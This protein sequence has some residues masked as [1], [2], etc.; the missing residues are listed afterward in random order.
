MAAISFVKTKLGPT[1]LIWLEK[2]NTYFQLEEPAWFVFRRI[3]KQEKPGT[4]AWEFSHRYQVSLSE[5]Q[6]FVGEIWNKI[7]GVN[8]SDSPE[9]NSEL[10]KFEQ[11]SHD[12][13]EPYSVQQYQLGNQIIEFR[14]G[15][16]WLENYIH[17]LIS[18][19]QITE[20]QNVS[21]LFELFWFQDEIVFRMN[22]VVKGSWTNNES[23]LVKGKIFM[24]L[25]NLLHNKAESDWL[26]TVHASA[27]TNG[28]KTMLFSASPGSGKTTIAALLKANG[29]QLISDD[30]V[31]VDRENFHAFPFPVA[32][33]VKKGSME[34]LSSHYPDL[35][36]AAL[37]YITDEKVVKYLPIRNETTNMIFPVQEFI[38]VRYDPSVEIDCEKLEPI[39]GIK[40][41]LEE[42]WVSPLKDHVKS[43]FEQIAGKSFYKLTYSNNQKAIERI[44]QLFEND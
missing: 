16:H 13:Y 3:S 42:T 6:D 35:E 5:S 14:F 24:E 44:T 15:F 33:S 2:S 19:L 41:L 40:R 37:N 27:I 22:K 31:P 38:F 4:I 21:E 30:F 25:S 20:K 17:P 43:F 32:M 29:Y 28:R 7:N 23:H 34:M 26:M 39:D 11:L 1:F 36:N 18:H 9:K 10:N 12:V 8:K